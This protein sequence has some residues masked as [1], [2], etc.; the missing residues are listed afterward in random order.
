MRLISFID[1]KDNEA[2]GLIVGDGVVDLTKR[3]ASKPKTLRALIASG[4]WEAEP[5]LKDTPD[6]KLADVEI[7]PV[8][9]NPDKILCVG[10]NYKA[11]VAESPLPQPEYPMIFTRFAAS[12][13]GHLRPMI[14][15]QASERFDWEGELAVVI[16]KTGRHIPKDKAMDYVAGYSCFNDGSIRDFQRHTNQFAPGKNFHHSGAM[17]P[18]LVTADEAGDPN[19]MVLETRLNGQVMQHSGVDDLL[20][21]IPDLIAYCSTFAELLPGDVIATGTCGGIGA[22]RKPPIWMKAGDTVEVEITHVGLL[23]NPIEDEKL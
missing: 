14:R 4:L 5:G 22:A 12:Q 13:V 9:T 16:G 21:K 11:H 6:Y 7:L 19:K 3:L 15:P 18:W 1:K 2:V 10:L 8:I 20:F 17:G 23:K